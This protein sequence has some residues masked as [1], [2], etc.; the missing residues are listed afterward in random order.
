MPGDGED[1]KVENAEDNDWDDT[2]CEEGMENLV[3]DAR[4]D[5]KLFVVS[6]DW[7]ENVADLDHLRNVEADSSDDNGDDVVKDT[8]PVTS[9]CKFYF[10]GDWRADG[11][12][13]LAGDGDGH[14]DTGGHCNMA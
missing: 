3:D 10:V 13:P 6:K 5:E 4:F 7:I 8:P 9:S 12:E 1:F 11:R 2:G 14:E